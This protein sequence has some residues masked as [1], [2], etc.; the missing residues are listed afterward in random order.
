MTELRQLIADRIADGPVRMN[1]HSHTQFCDGKASMEEMATAASEAGFS[2]WGFSPHSPIDIPSPCN[3]SEDD[4]PPFVGEAERIRK[5]LQGTTL[6]LTGMEIDYLSDTF[7]PALPCFRNLPL[8]Y[9]I[10][11]VH[12][13]P[14]Q[15][16]EPVDCDGSATRFKD[17]LRNK[18]DGD[19]EYVVRKYF[20]Q[21]LSMIRAGGFDILG[22]LDKI[23]GNASEVDPTIEDADWYGELV[24]EVIEEAVSRDFIIEINTKAYDSRHRFYPDCRWWPL[25]KRKGAE[26][27]F[28]TDAHYP[29]KVAASYDEAARLWNNIVI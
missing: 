24:K 23:A 8:D 11:S 27:I 21:V 6:I 22:H 7:G 26:V 1:L 2:V 18:F 15:R 28:S 4:V 14:T 20:E 5:K 29:D 10:G 9:R 17:Y 13:V 25:L 12:F 19:L 16:G 3:M